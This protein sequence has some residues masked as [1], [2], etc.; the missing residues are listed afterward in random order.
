MIA[1]NPLVDGRHSLCLAISDDEGDTWRPFHQLEAWL[2]DDG[3]FSYPCL[4]ETSD[5]RILVTY[6]CKRRQDGKRLKS[7]KHVTLEQPEQRPQVRV[8]EIALPTLR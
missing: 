8:A 6:S 7:I 5:G 1:Y 2:P 4:I 3:S